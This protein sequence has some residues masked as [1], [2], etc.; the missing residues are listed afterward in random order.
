VAEVATIP[1]PSAPKADTPKA[2][3]ARRHRRRGFGSVFK[4]G[5]SWFIR[6]R[7]GK[8][9][10]KRRA[11][12]R[13]A[14]PTRGHAEAMLETLRRQ[15]DDQ[16]ALGLKP[17]PAP[18]TLTEFL[19][20][21]LEAFLG[22]RHTP[23]TLRQEM[24]RLRMA[25]GFLG[26]KPMRDVTAA[27]LGD[28]V[29]FLRS[30][31]PRPGTRKSG[32]PLKPL[33]PASGTTVNRH[34]AALSVAFK[35]AR[36]RRVADGDPVGGVARFP[37]PLP[38]VEYLPARAFLRLLLALAP[39]DRPVA[40]FLYE[41]GCRRGEAARLDWADINL[42]DAEV[43]VRTSKNLEGRHIPLTRE[44]LRLLTA[45]C[46]RRGPVRA[47]VPTPVFPALRAVSPGT[48]WTGADLLSGAVPRAAEA[49]GLRVHVRCHDL[50]HACGSA[51]RRSGATD[52]VIAQI[53]G[54]RP[55]TRNVTWRYSNSIP[56]GDVLRGVRRMAS[57]RAREAGRSD[58][59]AA[60]VRA[61]RAAPRVA[62]GP[63]ESA[64][65]LRGPTSGPTAARHA[66]RQPSPDTAQLPA[67]E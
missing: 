27:D 51:L 60:A 47:R 16:D 28:Y 4:K 45:L 17:P 12:V 23:D 21:H 67:A 49:A 7:P 43:V 1:L 6:V 61:C 32:A 3:R 11:I 19:R 25:A 65:R 64:K 53:L 66:R 55:P 33:R 15:A 9:D 29:T 36:D 20:D 34:L 38:P 59:L 46:A 50:R 48:H 57:L 62:V 22:A 14:G 26:P 37:E 52:P 8:R 63:A 35:H 31:R 41:T 40:A 18:V 44:A 56:A 39:A 42:P 58:Y 13:R 54:H 24:V 10:V 2:G 30:P 5:P